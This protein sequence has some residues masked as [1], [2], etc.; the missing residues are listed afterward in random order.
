MTNML[1]GLSML[2][3]VRHH[4][5]LGRS[6]RVVGNGAIVVVF[7]IIIAVLFAHEVLGTFVFVCV[8]ILGV[9][10]AMC[11]LARGLLA[12]TY[13]LVTAYSGI[14]VAGREL[15]ELVVVTKDDDGDVYRAQDR[16]LVSF[17]EKTALALEKGARGGS[18]A[19]AM[20]GGGRVEACLH[21][22]ITVILDGL[23]LDFA[24]THDEV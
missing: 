2:E 21:G 20:G 7:V 19:V 14:D 4:R 11:E 24:A 5:V 22:A 9:V 23:D 17:L 12:A 13:V 18:A 16:E 3:V 10:S 6:M 15:I 8:T 1:E